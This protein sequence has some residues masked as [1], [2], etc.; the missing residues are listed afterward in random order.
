MTFRL[1]ALTA[2]LALWAPPLS[3]QGA[4]SVALTHVSVVEVGTGRLQSNQTV[5]I[6]GG[7][8]AAVGRT[9]SVPVPTGTMNVDATGKYLIP[10][11][12]DMH[13][14]VVDPDM[15]GGPEVSF[16]L[17]V[18]NGI[19]GIR[20][21]GSS[22]LDSIIKLRGEV[23]AGTR[24]GPRILVAGKVL[25]GVP[26]VAPPDEWPARTPVEARRAIDSLA[27]R[28]VDFI[29]S[30]E[31]LQRDVFLA[32]VDRAKRHR[33]PLAAHVPLVIDAA[34]AS[35]LG[36]WRPILP[37]SRV[38]VKPRGGRFVMVTARRR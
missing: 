28:G 4:P 14:H 5:V 19:T 18:A 25:D 8:I 38:R 37:M 16:P 11:L 32:I 6:N 27:T 22:D 7:R 24:L 29:K 23:R 17:L 1:F 34:E 20:D 9:G 31:M 36:V 35:D 2:L 10:G 21:M 15:P 26:L 33:L 13:T 3:G 30:Y 12:W